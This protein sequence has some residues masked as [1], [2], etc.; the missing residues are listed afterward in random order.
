M[1]DEIGMRLYDLGRV[2]DE[3]CPPSPAATPGRRWSPRRTTTMANALRVG[4]H[5]LE[6]LGASAAAATNGRPE[7][8]LQETS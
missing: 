2:L 1:N 6:R 7:L 5:L 4:D 8:E 3:S